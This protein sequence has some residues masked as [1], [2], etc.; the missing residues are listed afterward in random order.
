MRRLTASLS[1]VQLLMLPS[2]ERETMV[3]ALPATRDSAVSPTSMAA[4]LSSTGISHH[5]LFPHIPL[6]CLST[7]NS[8][9]RPGI[10]PLSLN[11]S[12]QPLHLPGDL[13]PCPG[14]VWLPQDCLILIPFRLPQ[15]AVSLSAFSVSPPTQTIALMW[16]SDLCFNSPTHQGQGQSY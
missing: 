10:A 15:I 7:V 5:S 2:G 1:I 16:G 13:H 12:S 14:Y 4:W 8:G 11:S 6:I 3:L 9:P